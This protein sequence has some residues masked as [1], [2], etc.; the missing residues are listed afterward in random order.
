[1]ATQDAI[2]NAYQKA[3]LAKHGI[4]LDKA[5]NTPMFAKCLERVADAIE[6]KQTA[7]PVTEYWFNKL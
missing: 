2:I 6:S 1:M 4:S 3:Q 5:L 7:K